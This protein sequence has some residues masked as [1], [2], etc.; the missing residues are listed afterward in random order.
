MMEDQFGGRTDD[1]L[2]ADDFEPLSDDNQPDEV[3]Q[4]APT[5]EPVST[6]AVP[7]EPAA[8]TYQQPTVENKGTR[9][10]QPLSKG[11]A[12][13]K[14]SDKRPTSRP[15]RQSPAT[16]SNN[17]TPPPTA[18]TGPSADAA[19]LRESKQHNGAGAAIPGQNT[20]LRS[21]ER[22]KSGANPR[23]KLT[24]EELAARLEKMRILNAETTRKFERAEA[25][26]RTHAEA[27][28][29]GME[30]ARRRRQ[31]EE[32]RRQRGEEERRRMDEERARNRERKLRAME[33]KEGGWDAGK[34][35]E[36]EDARDFHGA[37][38]GVRGARGLNSLAGSRYARDDA[39]SAGN[40]RFAGEEAPFRGR[41]RGRGRGGPGRG[42]GG[43]GGGG[44][45]GPNRDRDGPHDDNPSNV[46][47]EPPTKP[48]LNTEDF[49]ALPGT[50]NKPS[51]LSPLTNTNWGEEMEALDAK[52]GKKP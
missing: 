7:Q 12:N 39:Y 18:S 2:F 19:S 17:A 5:E 40:N 4:S 29:R 26:E 25:D 44:G 47:T 42:R 22:I 48:I 11:L 14:Y 27:Y 49:P 21:E 20:A 13:S 23:T 1:D 50:Q 28:A 37:H 8:Q 36:Q 10:T 30:E 43:R 38:G 3:V 46:S 51:P 52:L 24:E 6:A 35:E 32:E 15:R 16:S 31:A 41:G 45:G 33:N 34:K 9:N